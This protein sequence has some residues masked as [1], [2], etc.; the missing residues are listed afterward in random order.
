M[1]CLFKSARARG[2]PRRTLPRSRARK[3]YPAAPRS[4]AWRSSAPL[5]VDDVDRLLDHRY[6]FVLSSRILPQR[7]NYS[8]NPGFVDALE[9]QQQREK[10]CGTFPYG[11]V[12][13]FRGNIW[14]AAIFLLY[15]VVFLL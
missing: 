6:H 10:S 8:R 11:N 4:C 12:F 14:S 2:R 13:D 7:E 9:K 15:F 3:G 5:V 1:L